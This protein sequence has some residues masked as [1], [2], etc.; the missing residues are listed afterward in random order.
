MTEKM[1]NILLEKIDS[2]EGQVH[3]VRAVLGAL[4]DSHPDRAKFAAFL[5]NVSGFASESM[6]LQESAS[7][8]YL[9]SQREFVQRMLAYALLSPVSQKKR[10]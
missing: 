10:P 3:G 6:I 9:E 2:L 5:E 4:I 7:E 1:E 8:V